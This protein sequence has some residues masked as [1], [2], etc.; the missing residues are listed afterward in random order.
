MFERIKHSSIIK[1][2]ISLSI[3]CEIAII[4][5]GILL[6]VRHYLSNCSLWTDE[7]YVALSI[8][9]RSLS[10]I[11]RHVVIFPELAKAPLGFLVFEKIAILTTGNT[12]LVLKFF[13]FLF[14]TGALILFYFFLKRY[15]SYGVRSWSLVLF[16][17]S[18]IL[19]YYSAEVKQYSMDVFFALV[20]L[21][22]IPFFK[23]QQLNLKKI[24]FLSFLGASVVWFSN[25]CLFVLVG[26]GA[27]M[28]LE[29]LTKKEWKKIFFVT[30]IFTAWITSLAGL[31]QIS[32]KHMVSMDSLTSSWPG[33]FGPKP[34]FTIEG[35]TWLKTVF[36]E[37]FINPGAMAFPLFCGLLFFIGIIDLFRKER[38]LCCYL[39]IPIFI[40]LLAA[41]L[42]KYP[43]R[44][45]LLIFLVPSLII[46]VIHGIFWISSFFR[47]YK[48]ITVFFL[49]FIISH[50]ALIK[51]SNSFVS[52]YCQQD[53]R[54]MLSTFKEKYKEGDIFFSTPHGLLA[55]WYYSTSLNYGSF[56]PK[57]EFPTIPFL[58]GIKVGR[59]SRFDV[60]GSDRY[61]TYLYEYVFLDSNN[62]FQRSLPEEKRYYILKNNPVF[63]D[64]DAKRAWV[65]FSGPDSELQN[66]VIDSF[67]R[68]WQKI[69]QLEGRGA[70]IYL[71][72]LEND[73]FNYYKNFEASEQR[74]NIK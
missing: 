51:T 15:F 55:F 59:F 54:K 67:S 33:A 9:G 61:V 74:G 37:M 35:A 45:R 70:S 68:R 50:S 42:G 4:I 46:F 64:I 22:F 57:T 5:V 36:S 39:G 16:A 31:Y 14:G 44:G 71:F 48:T 69:W 49:V 12:E 23:I 21:L 66:I 53:N 40:T 34:F 30:P 62:C 24:F 32:F 11:I 1:K 63:N 13:P 28:C 20:L 6:R 7:T 18:P 58:R 41:I 26:I 47:K 2:I 8:V 17:L 10:E 29:I 25:A 27:T 72:N 52:S 56:F 38:K 60:T 65:F 73:I 43:F 3:N 19:V